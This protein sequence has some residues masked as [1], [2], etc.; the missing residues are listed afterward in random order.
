MKK[1]QGKW[2][3]ILFCF[4]FFALPVQA[5]TITQDPQFVVINFS[6]TFHLADWDADEETWQSSVKPELLKAIREMK[7]TVGTGTEQRKLAWSTL[8]EYTDYAMDEP[9]DRSPYVIRTRRIMEL[10]EEADL[11][12][13]MPLNGF[14]WWNEVPELWNWWDPDGNQTPG[15]ENDSYTTESCRMPE[16]K[17]PEFRKKFI[18]GYNPENK[19]N[20]EWS[21]WETPMKLNWRNWGSG[22]FQLAPPPN[23]VDHDRLSMTYKDFQTAR[24]EAILQV[25]AD[26]YEEWQAEDKEY[27]FAG[28]TLGTEVSLNASV[29]RKD[30]FEPY[31]YRG[32]QDSICQKDDVSCGEEKD[33]S[34]NELH[35]LRQKVVNTY[36]TDLSYRAIKKGLPKQRIYT[37]VWSEVK[38]D[39]PRYENYFQASINHYARPS[40]SLYGFAQDPLSLPLLERTLQKEGMPTWGA[41]EFSTDKDAPSWNK[42]LSNTLENPINPAK[43]IDIY[44]WKEHKDTPAV[45]EIQAILKE[46]VQFTKPVSEVFA[47]ENENISPSTLEWQLLSEDEADEQHIVLFKT[48]QSILDIDEKPYKEIDVPTIDLKWDV[49]GL[50]PGIYHWLVQRT[51]KHS[52]YTY[53]T[54]SIPQR[55]FIPIPVTSDNSPWWVKQALSIQDSFTDRSN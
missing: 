53:T 49:I 8:L 35:A 46:E 38:E 24:Y 16:L 52:D 40:L 21:D 36:L 4:L 31:G 55:L 12:V 34:K 25:I 19:W 41:S 48:K 37:H 17:D 14:Q 22:G 5:S 47:K 23:L 42:A 44:N 13:F 33:P 7:E 18:K 6:D 50:E 51:S 11:P 27:L 2:F 10:A 1:L 9:S 3:F 29:T 20:V 43:I 32:I 39:E 26:Q 15:C 30:E 45:G 28:I 54:S